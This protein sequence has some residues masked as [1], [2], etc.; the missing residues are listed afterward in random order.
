MSMRM[1]FFGRYQGLDGDETTTGAI[2]IASQAR[3]RVHGRN[4][5]LQGEPTTPCPLCGQAGTIVEGIAGMG[6]GEELGE[7][8]FEAFQDD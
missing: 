2:C 6:G 8:I 5:L 3:G 1:N 4:W 7:V